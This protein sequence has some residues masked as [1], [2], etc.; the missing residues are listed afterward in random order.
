MSVKIAVQEAPSL[1]RKT[2]KIK[3][4]VSVRNS[5]ETSVKNSKVYSNQVNP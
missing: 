1:Q 4:K 3:P 2:K 5:A